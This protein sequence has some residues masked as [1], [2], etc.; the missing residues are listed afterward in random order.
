MQNSSQCCPI[1]LGIGEN[2][3]TFSRALRKLSATRSDAKGK[4]SKFFAFQSHSRAVVAGNPFFRLLFSIY[5]LFLFH[6]CFSQRHFNKIYFIMLIAFRSF[7]LFYRPEKR[8]SYLSLH[9]NLPHPFA[10]TLNSTGKEA[11]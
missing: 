11:I 9:Q 8:S 3:Q 1:N 5:K 7:S 10:P 4:F 2:V 6:F